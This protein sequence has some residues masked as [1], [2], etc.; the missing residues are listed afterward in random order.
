MH[1]IPSVLALQLTI[2]HSACRLMNYY[3]LEIDLLYALTSHW[4]GENNW[5]CPPVVLVPRVIRHAQACGAVGTLVVSCWLSA[6]FWPILCPDGKF[7]DGFIVGVVELPMI[8]PPVSSWIVRSSI[9][10]WT[11]AEYPSA[12]TAL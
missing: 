2:F 5:W 7:F 1:R 3:N 4:G 9:I 12:R 11:V 8:Q 10:R 6:P